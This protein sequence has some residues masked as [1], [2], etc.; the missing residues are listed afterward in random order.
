V[1]RAESESGELFFAASNT[2]P[3]R[4]GS[5]A[6][7]AD[8]VQRCMW[9][10]R[11]RSIVLLLDCCFGGAFSQGVRVRGVSDVNVL[12]SFQ[13]ASWAAGVVEQ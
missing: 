5:T 10:S 8:F 6:L 11:S 9:T 2:R 7:S 1:L 3:D 13:A 4:L 12:A